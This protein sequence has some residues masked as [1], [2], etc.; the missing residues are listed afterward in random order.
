MPIVKDTPRETAGTK[1]RHTAGLGHRWQAPGSEGR[2]IGHR[3]QGAREQGT[4]AA[5]IDTGTQGHRHATRHPP[6]PTEEAKGPLTPLK[7]RAIFFDKPFP[8][9]LN[10]AKRGNWSRKSRG[11][12]KT[13]SRFF[14]KRV[15]LGRMGA[16]WD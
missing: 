8:M 12:A 16:S 1:E 11:F 6:P 15:I 5:G 9:Q 7:I 2:P 14:E 13:Q 10:L 4:R 3:R